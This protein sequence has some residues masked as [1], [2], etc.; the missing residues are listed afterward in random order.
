MSKLTEIES[1][2]DFLRKWC[3][4]SLETIAEMT[5]AS[6]R[7][8]TGAGKDAAA[9]RRRERSLVVIAEGFNKALVICGEVTTIEGE[10]K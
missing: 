10:T 3:R 5:R 7:T 6:D 4:G 9:R 2:L 8:P 1:D